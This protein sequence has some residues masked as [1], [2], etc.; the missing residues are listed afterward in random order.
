VTDY[1]I[2]TSIQRVSNI[3]GV[4]GKT[5]LNSTLL[6]RFRNETTNQQQQQS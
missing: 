4:T 3:L 6:D 5:R 1:F 2:N